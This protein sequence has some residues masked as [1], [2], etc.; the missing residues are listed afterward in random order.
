[1]PNTFAIPSAAK[2][3]T[4]SQL[5]YNNSLQSIW[6]NFYG[7]AIPNSG[8]VTILGLAS[9]PLTG[10]LY[11]SSVFNTFYVYDPS[12][13]KG[14]SIGGGYTRQG[15]GTRNFESIANLVSNLASIEQG[16]LLTTVG[17]ST[18]NY[19]VYMKTSNSNSIVDIGVPAAGSLVTSM[20]S[21]RQ[22]SNVHIQS[23]IISQY[24]L[25]ASSVVEAKIASSAVTTTKI[26]DSAVTEAKLGSSAV[27]ADKIGT[28]AVTAAKI[29]DYS[30]TGTKLSNNLTYSSNLTV[31]GNVILGSNKRIFFADGTSQ[32]TASTGSNITSAGSGTSVIFSSSNTG[33]VLRSI[34]PSLTFSGPPG[35]SGSFTGSTD[36]SG[37]LFLNLTIT[38]P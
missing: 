26:A 18:A 22:I 6:S 35:S 20:F 38:I 23:A 31:N 4:L 8:D 11:R 36:G 14:G 7:S 27:T 9:S 13:A 34:I 12:R 1:M 16:E 30:I 33:V 29:P 10:S 5:D 25:G 37:N 28:G 15:I 32:N 21:N 17:D 19:R 2:S 3:F 24:E